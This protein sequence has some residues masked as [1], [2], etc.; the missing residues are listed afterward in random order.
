MCLHG[1]SRTETSNE[2]LRK[3][4]ILTDMLGDLEKLSEVMENDGNWWKVATARGAFIC[5]LGSF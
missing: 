1:N 5:Q 4:L 3:S 2:I